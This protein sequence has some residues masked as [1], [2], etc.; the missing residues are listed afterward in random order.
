MLGEFRSLVLDA[1]VFA[2]A[3]TAPN[4]IDFRLPEPAP[5]APSRVARALART[6]SER[7]AYTALSKVEFE[8]G[9]VRPRNAAQCQWVNV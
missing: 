5:H 6:G 2:Y 3:P 1:L 7:E 8:P 4:V 9:K